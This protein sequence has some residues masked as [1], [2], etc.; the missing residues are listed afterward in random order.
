MLPD[1]RIRYQAPEINFETEVGIT[2]QDHD[3]YPAPDTQARYDHMRMTLIGLLSQQSSYYEPNEHRD[4]TPWFDLNTMQL[5]IRMYNQWLPYSDAIVLENDITLTDWVRAVADGLASLAPEITFNGNCASNNTTI[6]P[7]PESLRDYL[8]PD[9][10]AFVH[11]NGLLLDPRYTQITGSVIFLSDQ[12]LN[13]GDKFTVSI[14]RIISEV[15][16]QQDVNIP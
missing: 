9:S 4:G 12:I 3:Q 15:W 10:R 16:Y 11:K 7:I 6:I 14:R 13:S 2:S 8:Y 1:N 5:K